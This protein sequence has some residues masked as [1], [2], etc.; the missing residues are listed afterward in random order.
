[1]SDRPTTPGRIVWHEMNSQEPQLSAAFYS[2]LFGW[3][4]DFSNPRYTMIHSGAAAVGGMIKLPPLDVPS[5]WLPYM[6]VLDV[7]GSSA[8]ATAAGCSVITGTMDVPSGRFNVLQDPLGALFCVWRGTGEDMP[9]SDAVHTGHFCWDQLN[10]P[11]ASASFEAYSAVFGW[12]RQAGFASASAPELSTLLLASEPVAG[13][14][15]GPSSMPAHWLCFVAV[16]SLGT[17]LEHTRQLGGKVLVDEVPVPGRGAFCVL[18]DSLGAVF[19]AF[20]A[21]ND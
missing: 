19:A 16:D 3:S 17:T 18:Q 21:S 6:A 10:T 14:M 5:H 11:N 2:E 7:D 13:L 1:M 9:S 15:Q 8:R 12:E 4:F 20:R